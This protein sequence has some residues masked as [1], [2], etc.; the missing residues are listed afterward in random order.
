MKTLVSSTDALSFLKERF[1]DTKEII[2][3]RTDTS[4]TN[5]KGQRDK[6]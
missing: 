1:G 3:S 5:K 6:Q 2:G 4:T